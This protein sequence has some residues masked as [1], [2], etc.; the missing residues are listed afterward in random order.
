MTRMK[1]IQRATKDAA[2]NSTRDQA[3]TEKGAAQRSGTPARATASAD[4]QSSPRL[5]AQRREMNELLGV[6]V[7]RMQLDG[8]N[9]VKDNSFNMEIG[10]SKRIDDPETGPTTRTVAPKTPIT[11]GDLKRMEPHGL[12]ERLREPEEGKLAPKSEHQ[13]SRFSV[14]KP[15]GK[16]AHWALYFVVERAGKHAKSLK[17]DLYERGYRAIYQEES[18][19]YPGFAGEV[20][21]YSMTDLSVATVYSYLSSIAADKGAYGAL[22][23][24]DCHAFVDLMLHRLEPHGLKKTQ[25]DFLNMGKVVKETKHL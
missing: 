22:G 17:V 8:I 12:Y 15:T 13:V 14:R 16:T 20:E 6:P 23:Q 25:T 19:P 21:W 9:T 1:A 10:R 4:V 7:Q 5:V 18:S 24:Y 2:E 3:G 11:V